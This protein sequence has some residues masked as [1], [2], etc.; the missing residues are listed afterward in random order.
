MVDVVVE[1]AQGRV[2]GE[3]GEGAAVFMGIPY[4][5]PPTGA[6]RFRP[7]EPAPPWAGVR[8]ALEAGPVAPQLPS[9]LE[10]LLGRRELV[11]DEA[12]C[13]TLNVWTPEPGAGARPVLV[14]IH[15]GAFLNGSGS[16]PW[17]DGTHLARD[18]DVVVVTINYR[19]G[20]FGFLHLAD[21]AGPAFEGS[22]LCGILDQV[23]ALRWV[24]ENAAAFGGD[25]GNVT[26]FGESAGGMSVGTLL[27]LDAARGLFHRAI[28]ESGAG[29]HASSREEADRITAE[30][31]GALDLG[32][33]GAARLAELPADAILQAQG[34]I[35]QTYVSRGLAF[36]PVVDGALLP[37]RP[38][39]RVA[40]GS[41]RDVAV[42]AGTNLDEWNLFSALDPKMEGL[43]EDRLVEAVGA[44]FGDRE[45]AARVV[46]EYRR[47]RPGATPAQV[48]AAA[49]TDATFRIPAIRLAEAQHRAGGRAWMY[50]FTWATPAFGGRLGSCHAL[51]LPFVFDNLDKPGADFLVGPEP[52]AALAKTMSATWAGFS[53][54]GDPAGGPLGLWPAYEPGSR[55]TMVFDAQSRL[56]EDPMGTERALWEGVR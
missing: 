26:V 1:T 53:R 29:H 36:Q 8:D 35:S 13:L 49:T 24:Q 23:A 27:A 31:L 40:A 11:W 47:G 6:R 43:D 25:P 55:A 42:L 17:Y 33:G 7:P 37:A 50:L 38:V 20:A 2:R 45:R 12:G 56:E 32:A 18:N 16:V 14:W 19:L 21:Q 22:G 28:L 5:A 9:P 48:L 39:E 10:N 3:R 4:A 34:A 15:G 51:E 44:H 41:A 30:L 52:P 54:A 46:A